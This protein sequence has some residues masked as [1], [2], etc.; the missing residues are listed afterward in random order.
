MAIIDQS[1]AYLTDTSDTTT[2]TATNSSFNGQKTLSSSQP[3]NNTTITSY[4]SSACFPG[5]ARIVHL[6]AAH[7]QKLLSITMT[8]YGEEEKE[9]I[10][11]ELELIE[12]LVLVLEAIGER[13]NNDG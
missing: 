10:A 5:L 6:I 11:Q 8:K 13:G 9:E 3:K 7:H 12:A 1:T 4:S 2:A